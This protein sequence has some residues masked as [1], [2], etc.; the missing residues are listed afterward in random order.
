MKGLLEL[1]FTGTRTLEIV[2]SP[3]NGKIHVL[4]MASFGNIIKVGGLTQSGGVMWEIWHSTLKKVRAQKKEI[5]TCL[6]LGLGGG[7]AAEII[8]Q[9]W[10]GVRITG[11]DID[12]MMI[13][14][15]RKYLKLDA[16][17]IDIVVD[18]VTYFMDKNKKKYDLILIDLY[19][20]VEF[21]KKFEEETFLQQVH[22]ALT[23]GG[24]ALFNRFSF[25]ENREK[26]LSF[27]KKLEDVF[28]KIDPL[29]L[30]AKVNLMFMCER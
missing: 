22:N 9:M 25:L 8:S 6:I 1:L 5:K 30:K 28:G 18:D 10:T 3:Y 26:A 12:P 7:S 2:D 23:K 14:L 15:G 19:K 20:G 17:N 13:Q 24:I 21:P 27:G 11:V 16:L 29:Y 4:Q